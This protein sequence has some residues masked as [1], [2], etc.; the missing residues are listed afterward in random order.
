MKRFA[1]FL[2]LVTL[3]ILSFGQTIV[4]LHR[5]KADRPTGQTLAGWEKSANF[6]WA[7]FSQL[8]PDK[9]YGKLFVDVQ[10]GKVFADGK[11]FVDCIPKRKPADIVADYENRKGNPGFDLKKFVLD[12]FDLPPAPSDTYKTNTAEDVVTHIKNLWAVLRRT[13][14]KPV[15][16]SS[17][18]P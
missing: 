10:M 12:N 4:T 6:P 14:D 1:G 16:G 13:P 11:T 2:L 5:P 15:E 7:D 3:S 18:L 8:G 9:I 17:L